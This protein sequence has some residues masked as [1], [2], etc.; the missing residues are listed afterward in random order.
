MCIVKWYILFVEIYMEKKDQSGHIHNT[1]L[2][3]LLAVWALSFVLLGN[4]DNIVAQTQQTKQDLARNI[5]KSNED[6]LKQYFVN[7]FAPVINSIDQLTDIPIKVKYKNNDLAQKNNF[8]DSIDISPKVINGSPKKLVVVTIDD[9][10]YNIVP[11]K[12]IKIKNMKLVP[13]KTLDDPKAIL[14]L[15]LIGFFPWDIEISSREFA[16][17]IYDLSRMNVGQKTSVWWIHV[18]VLARNNK[19][20]IAPKNP[21]QMTDS[22]QIKNEPVL[23]KYTTD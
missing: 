4:S 10:K 15:E 13:N 21:K 1:T 16:A 5:N 22:N 2:K 23:A 11:Y 18:E 6:I 19:P 9:K 14:T 7:S 12:G 17:Y 20:N 3:N 8:P